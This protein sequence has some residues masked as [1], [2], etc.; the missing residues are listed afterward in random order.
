VS[1]TR[2]WRP[3]QIAGVSDGLILFDGV[4]VL[5][6]GWVRFI[7]ERDRDSVFRF[8]PVQQ[9]YGT[10]LARHLGITVENPETN[11][12]VFGD[13]AY[14]KSDAAIAAL[15]RLPGWSWV[16]LFRAVPRPLR[17]WIYDQ[18][19]RHRYR[20][21]GRSDQCLMPTKELSRRFILDEPM[22]TR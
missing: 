11:A 4:C 12:V 17:D 18:V 19:A 15:S 3:V 6:S 5:C 22:A 2:N 10:A 14:F 9:A 20:W 21:F 13:R 7:I 1:K 8:A 16:R